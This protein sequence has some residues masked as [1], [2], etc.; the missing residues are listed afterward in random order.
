MWQRRETSLRVEI[1]QEDRNRNR[2]SNRKSPPQLVASEK[3]VNPQ[4][5]FGE[6][7]LRRIAEVH[8]RASESGKTGECLTSS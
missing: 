2:G 6:L 5:M 8:S 7:F 4:L 3:M 1:E